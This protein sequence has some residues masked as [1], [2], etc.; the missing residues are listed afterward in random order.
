VVE[1]VVEEL[2]DVVWD[3]VV[4]AALEPVGRRRAF[5]VQ[6]NFWPPRGNWVVSELVE[7]FAP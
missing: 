3:G 6:H 7:L 4:G 1:E 2:T 5:A